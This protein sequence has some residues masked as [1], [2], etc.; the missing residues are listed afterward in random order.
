MRDKKPEV[1]NR[2]LKIRKGF[3]LIELLVATGIFSILAAIGIG[4]FVQMLRTQRS[5]T[6]QLTAIS[7]AHIALEQM[8][9]EIRTG[10][11]FSCRNP[12]TCVA[13]TGL[14]FTNAA[15]LPVE[16][17][18]PNR[19]QDRF[20]ERSENGGSF[21][22]ITGSNVLVNYLE[23]SIFLGSRSSDHYPPRINIILQVSPVGAS[24]TPI[25]IQTTVSS[26]T[27]DG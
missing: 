16:Y 5:V 13:S 17:R 10:Y 20:I 2:I 15:G 24:I 3:T 26:R 19:P 1:K 11:N 21:E 9:R 6:A 8:T 7:N 23:F 4:G 22:R 27:L 12:A 14:Q 25:N 18:I